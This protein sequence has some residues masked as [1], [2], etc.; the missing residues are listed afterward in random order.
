MANAI[1]AEAPPAE[2]PDAHRNNVSKLSN[3]IQTLSVRNYVHTLG[4][5]G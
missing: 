1:L 3:L 4:C 5:S 2:V